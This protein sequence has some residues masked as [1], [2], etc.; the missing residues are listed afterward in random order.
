MRFNVNDILSLADGVNSYQVVQRDGD[1]LKLLCTDFE[2][3]E[4]ITYDLSVYSHNTEFW[5]KRDDLHLFELM[6]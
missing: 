4:Q 5:V 6:G 3:V 1:Y 2:Q